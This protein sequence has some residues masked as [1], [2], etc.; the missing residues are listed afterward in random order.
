[1]IG[2]KDKQIEALENQLSLTKPEEMTKLRTDNQFL[3]EFN[4][5]LEGTLGEYFE[6]RRLPCSDQA[7]MERIKVLETEVKNLSTTASEGEANVKE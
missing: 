5:K 7:A 1:M 3:M 2:Q 4:K 6:N